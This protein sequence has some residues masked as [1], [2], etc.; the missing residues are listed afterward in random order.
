[1]VPPSDNQYQL[2]QEAAT[3][4]RNEATLRAAAMIPGE[5]AKQPERLARF[6]V[7]HD[8]DVAAW[9]FRVERFGDWL[10]LYVTRGLASDDAPSKNKLL[11]AVDLGKSRIIELRVGSLPATDASVPFVV[12]GAFGA[13]PWVI[14]APYEAPRSSPP[15]PRLTSILEERH[16]LAGYYG[17]EILDVYIPNCAR[18][19]V[20]D[21]IEFIGAEA[22]L[23][24]PAGRGRETYDVIL[25]ALAKS[26]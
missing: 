2:Q 21:V 9:S 4:R 23:A 10:A 3:K 13:K 8:A 24:V 15:L 17:G 6:R 11:A 7:L 19:A 20:D 12:V 22:I 26:A 16:P 25:A 14:E 1:M 5:I 18:N